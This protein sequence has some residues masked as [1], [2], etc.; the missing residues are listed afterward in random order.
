MWHEWE[1]E[2]CVQ[3]CGGE[4]WRKLGRPS[5][6]REDDVKMGLYEIE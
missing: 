1:E 2:T 3:E 4:T 6:G 5:H